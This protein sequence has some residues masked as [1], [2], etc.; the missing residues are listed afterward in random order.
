[1]ATD[2]EALARQLGGA[3]ESSAGAQ[4]LAALASQFGGTAQ[5][6]PETTAAGLAGAATR[7]LAPIAAGMALGAAAG[8]PLAGVGAIPGALVGA[9]AAGLA[10]LVGDPLVSGINSLLG[11]RY[12]TPTDAMGDLLTR[13]ARRCKRSPSRPPR[14]LSVR[15]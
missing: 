7:G 1:M 5:P 10:Q 11:T 13:L 4:D 3:V 14:E 8:A 15:H 9:G 6:E 2:Y 12:K